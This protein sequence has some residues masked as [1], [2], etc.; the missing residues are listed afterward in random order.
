MKSSARRVGAPF[1]DRRGAAVVPA[2][3]DLR[4]SRRGSPPMSVPRC[5]PW[6]DWHEWRAVFHGL[7]AS[8][9][10]ARRG[11]IAR[12]ATW[13]LRGGVPHAAECTATLV[14]L[15]LEPSSTTVA[16]LALSAAVVR[17]VNGVAD[18]GQRGETAR[19][20]AQLAEAAGLPVWLVDVRHRA[21]HQRLPSAAVLRGAAAALLASSAVSKIQR[22][23]R[24]RR[25]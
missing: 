12:C 17:A 14:E 22:G 20:V 21:T 1:V 7:Y 18:A 2:L 16:R 4:P 3:A 24:R 23:S 15:D 9:E 6:T 11:A 19:P 10:G 25:G 8:D 5:V 13:R